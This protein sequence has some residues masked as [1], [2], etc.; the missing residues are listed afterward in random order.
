[1]R[2]DFKNLTTG[3]HAIVFSSPGRYEVIFGKNID[4]EW[5]ES[6]GAP[7]RVYKTAAGALRAATR[8]IA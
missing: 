7:G 1:M 6:L 3:R 2:K 4:G 8:W 5:Y